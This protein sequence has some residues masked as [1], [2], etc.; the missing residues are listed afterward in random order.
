MPVSTEKFEELV[1]LFK[2]AFPDWAGFSDAEFREAELEYKRKASS[3][4][5]EQLGRDELTKLISNAQWDQIMDSIEHVGKAT[6]LLWTN[7][8]TS[9]DLGILYVEE[10]DKP[11][12]CQ[13][14]FDLVHGAGTSVERLDAFL[15]FVAEA[16]LPSKWTFP[17]YFLFLL[18]PET[19]FFVKPSVT[20]WLLRDYAAD[21]L[22]KP[23]GKAY[24]KVLEIA[25]SLREH[26]SSYEPQD[27]IDVQSFVWQCWNS[28]E[29]VT[30]SP[31][32]KAEFAELFQEFIE[33]Y[34]QSE[35]GEWHAEMYPLGRSEARAGYEQLRQTSEEPALT[36]LTLLKLLPYADTPANR[37]R[38]AWISH[39]P[40]FAG[41]I[42]TKFENAGWAKPAAWPE[43][44]SAIRDLVYGGIEEP[45]ALPE[46]CDAFAESGYS[47]GLQAG[48]IS[49][50]LNALDPER[51]VIVNSKVVSVL[52]FLT[53]SSLKTTLASY[54]KTNEIALDV[55]DSLKDELQRADLPDLALSD[56]FDMFC[57]WMVAV[58]H[59]DFREIQ[60]WKIA[61]G[62]NAH[63]WD[64]W[65]EGGYASIGWDDLG[66]ISGLT[67]AEFDA[68]R[69]RLVEEYEDWH[70]NGANQVWRFAKHIHEG[71]QIVANQGKSKVLA[72]GTV[73]GDYY[74]VP[75]AEHGHRLPVEWSDLIP[76]VV[77]E[78]SWLNTLKKL[79]RE[80]FEAIIG[81]AAPPPP[82]PSDLDPPLAEAFRTQAQA[83][84]AF[85]ILHDVCITLGIEGPDDERITITI[86]ET[87]EGVLRL[88]YLTCLVIGYEKR[89]HGGVQL[90]LALDAGEDTGSASQRAETAFDQIGEDASDVHL[91]DVSLDDF[92]AMGST[93][94]PAFRGSVAYFRRRF[95]NWSKS[96]LRDRGHNASA[97]QAIFDTEMR[98]RVVAGQVRLEPRDP[99]G[100]GGLNPIYP[101]EQCAE[102]TG[103]D[104][105]TLER[106]ISAINRKKQAIIYGPPG[107]GKTFM[108]ELVARHLVGGTQG[109]VELVQFHPAYA[110]EDFIQGIRPRT[111]SDG[112]LEYP[113]VAGR[114][115]E[116]CRRARAQD[117]LSVLIIDEINR[118]DL[119]RV[120]GELMYLLEYR[121]HQVPL[122]GGGMFSIP[123]K[124]RII[125]TMNTADRSIALV[126]H[127]LRRRFAF[128]GLYPDYRL[129][130]EFLRERD[131]NP[132][133][134]IGVLREVNAQI[135]DPHYAVGITFFLDEDLYDSVEDIWRMEIYPYLEEQFFD[136]PNTLERFQ[137]DRVAKRI[138][139]E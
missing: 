65:L 44:A 78:P 108:A 32:R 38:G 76:R 57:H 75:N 41:D 8:P 124:V 104:L 87:G 21:H 43:I 40:A 130:E 34:V 81:S 49:P 3:L 66:D 137:W 33:A 12:F 1:D 113:M 94:W 88:N 56:T 125:G 7:V 20:Q 26:L 2:T 10:L 99:D 45:G 110:Y 112:Q 25:Q 39:A 54:P 30:V 5:R 29:T 131:F 31:K 37:E 86:P 28:H 35:T 117:A 53:G 4:A 19:E 122:A 11:R 90:V 9:G 103:F 24:S 42:H 127:A 82:P 128:L 121:D 106:W 36:D 77:D 107:T 114:F 102:E 15:G 136:N 92:K 100:P 48:T 63:L 80:K 64:Q 52:N 89:R 133:G 16:V 67:R 139:G 129:L 18:H 6:N 98:R 105:E 93:Q 74:F 126:D 115:L 72:V 47:T 123:D 69:D 83:V 14:F 134:L 120:F 17:T 84:E 132:E 96:P 13:E 118:A 79:D 101:L 119:S 111:T 50:I 22:G 46:L 60:Y 68:I 116:F 97:C 51:F 61:P 23:S 138:R 135:G 70:K 55:V 27:M 109:I 62:E 91:Y 85:A 58:K 73:V 95:A 59:F 71:D